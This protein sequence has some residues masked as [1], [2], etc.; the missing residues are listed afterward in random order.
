MG[1]IYGDNVWVL[2]DT[3]VFRDVLADTEAVFFSRSDNSGHGSNSVVFDHTYE[4]F[5]DFG[6]AVRN[7][8]ATHLKCF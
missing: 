4:F 5:G 2:K 1:N 6:M 7:F 3:E 8:Q